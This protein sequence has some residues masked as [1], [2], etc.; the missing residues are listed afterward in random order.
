MDYLGQVAF[1]DARQVGQEV[2]LVQVPSLFAPRGQGPAR[3]RKFYK[4]GRP[5]SG[6]T[7][8]EAVPANGKFALR[9]DFENL[10][11]AELGVLLIALGQGDPALHLK[12][13]GGKPACYGSVRIAGLTL[14][15][16]RAIQDDYLA[17]EGT[18]AQA[19]PGEFVAAA[20][21]DEQL[22]LRAQ[23]AQLGETLKYPNDR[24]CPP[25]NY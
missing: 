2:V 21:A 17:W 7:P 16:R 15:L 9:C 25:G 19:E 24:D 14:H 10:T 20:L 22:L 1:A 23:L 13:G 8:T 4:H 18:E 12:L 5:A 11:A 3:G 6:N